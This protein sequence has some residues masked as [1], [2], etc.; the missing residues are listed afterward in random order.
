MKKMALVIFTI[1]ISL[2]FQLAFGDVKIVN[3]VKNL[4]N[5]KDQGSGENIS[6]YKPDRARMEAPG[7]AISIIRLDKGVMWIVN[8]AEK[9]YIEMNAEQMSALTAIMGEI[10][11]PE[12]EKTSETKKIGKYNCTKIIVKMEMMGSKTE[13]EIW[14]TK[15][16]KPDPTLLKFNEKMLE[17]F[18]GNPS[19]ESSYKM[20]QK[21]Y[22]MEFYPVQTTTKAKIMGFSSE[23][24]T[25]L[26]EIS[27]EKLEDSLFEIPDGYEK[28]EMPNMGN[29]GGTGTKGVI[30]GKSKDV[31]KD[32]SK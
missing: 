8:D 10:K 6:Y 29:M 1:I 27:T 5:G 16:I 22:D 14:G 25:S 3:E 4:V 7:G 18:K 21:V 31:I 23:N 17:V 28:Q 15:D 26:K 2:T 19:M 32:K 20:M 30:K 13:T 24:T 11:E 12:V 9:T